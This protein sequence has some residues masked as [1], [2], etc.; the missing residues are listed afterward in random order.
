LEIL[1]KKYSK[2]IVETIRAERIHEKKCIAEGKVPAIVFTTLSK[3]NNEIYNARCIGNEFFKSLVDKELVRSY[4][5]NGRNISDISFR[6][7]LDEIYEKVNTIDMV[8]DRQYWVDYYDS[9]ARYEEAG[10]R[11]PKIPL[12]KLLIEHKLVQGE[13]YKTIVERIRKEALS[14]QQYGDNYDIIA[15][16]ILD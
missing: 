2:Y 12:A 3:E 1:S 16:L 8:I 13:K 6:L 10:S 15:D 7:I 5:T 9:V 14:P 4:Q 11:N